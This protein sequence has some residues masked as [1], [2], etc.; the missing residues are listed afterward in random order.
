MAQ[1][2]DE[3]SHLVV[4]GASAGG[5]ESLSVLV[6]SLPAT[7]AAPI[8]VG[9][10]LSPKRESALGEILA[11]QSPLPVR[12]VTDR[13]SLEPGV[14]YVVPPNRDVV[15]AGSEIRVHEDGQ[16]PHPSIDLLFST[17]AEAY[18][19]NVIAVVLSGT[20]SDGA[21]GARDVKYAGGTV[22]IQNP[23]TAAY[24][25]MPLSLAPSVVD[26]VANQDRIGEL[27]DVL[28]SGEFDVPPVSE[29]T[30]LQTFLDQIRDYTGIDFSSYKQPTIQRRL[31][32]RMVA[33]GQPDIPQYIRHVRNDPSE[34]QRLISSF[35]IKVTEFYRDPDLFAHLGEQVVPDLVAEAEARGA[36]LRIW[37]AGCATGEEAYSLAM[38]IADQLGGDAAAPNVR[39]F[40]TDL[41]EDAVAFARRGIYPARSLRN[42]PEN[43]VERHFVKLGD[44]YEV[45]KHLRAMLVFGEH[46]LGQRAPFPRIDLILCRNVLIYFTPALQRRALQLFAFS[47]RIDGYLVLGKSETVNGMAEFFAVDRPR[48]KSYRRV[49][50]RVLIPSSRVLDPMPSPLPRPVGPLRNSHHANT[51]RESS[52]SPSRFGAANQALLGLPFGVVVV[53]RA[54]DIHYLNSQA[55]RMFGI[56]TTALDQDFIHLVHHFDAV[57]VRG[58]IDAA[59][60]AEQAADRLLES[61]DSPADARRTVEIT[62]TPHLPGD[63]QEVL[64]V[65]TAIDV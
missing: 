38:T 21:A 17:A 55:R 54:Y 53:D 14:I 37:S 32:R 58:V 25:G 45:G 61:L 4:I 44:D 11:R 7:F 15:I 29:Q 59:A 60:S 62:C 3:L 27:L 47:L 34:R 31:K 51:G 18:G 8:V 13:D 30:Q 48:L 42:L 22:I 56:H 5:I 24:P 46:D 36:D 9:Q 49:G 41:D 52:R 16:G 39:I 1:S 35:L 20:G 28:V 12:V 6:G 26:I 10:H 43:M 19:E 33:T 2:N 23:E 50:D 63:D 57:A 64:F 40:A 65:L